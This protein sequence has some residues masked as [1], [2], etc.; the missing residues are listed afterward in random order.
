MASIV[1]AFVASVIGAIIAGVFAYCGSVQGA[2]VAAKHAEHL[3]T[4]ERE[5]REAERRKEVGNSI[6]AELRF[7]GE[8][9]T[10]PRVDESHSTLV[11]DAWLSARGQ[12]DFLGD[13]AGPKVM[14]TYA[15]MKRYNDAV[16]YELHKVPLGNGAMNRNLESQRERIKPLVQESIQL[17]EKG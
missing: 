14:L 10:R 4:K 16:F 8:V 11:V 12:I 15:E 1:G 9:L 5:S 7:N 6:L 2:K 3:F 13:T 17:L